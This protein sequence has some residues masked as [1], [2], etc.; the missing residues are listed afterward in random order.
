MIAMVVGIMAITMVVCLMLNSFFLKDLY[1]R[2]K[3]KALTGY[4]ESI[5]RYIENNDRDALGSEL[6]AMRYGDNISFYVYYTEQI[7]P[8]LAFRDDAGNYVSAA[9]KSEMEKRLKEI[10][11]DRSG[12]SPDAQVLESN[13]SFTIQQVSYSGAVSNSYMELYGLLR[14]NVYFLMR[15]PL[16]PVRE[17]ADAANRLLLITMVGTT[18]LGALLI[19]LSTQRVTG[20][21]LRLA[22]LSQHMAMLDFTSRYEGRQNNEISVLGSSMNRMSDKL[23]STIEELQQANDQL[24]K[25]IEEKI[26]IDEVRKEFLS[27]VSHELKTP[28]ALIQGYAE[29]LQDSVNDD[30]ESRNFY[31]EVIIDEA[32][33]MN[34][35]VKKLL[36]LNHLEFGQD[37]LSME[38]FCLSEMLD[39]VLSS[40]ELIA[41]G[42]GITVEKCYPP[43]CMAYADE[44]KIEE[45]CTNYIS[46]AFNHADGEKRI[47]V[48][49]DEEQERYRITVSNTG[50]RIPEDQLDKV[51]IKFYKVDKA[52]TREYGGSGIGLSIVKAVMDAHGE[53]YGVYNT[54]E[55][56][57]FWFC[58]RKAAYP[59]NS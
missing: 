8:Y 5:T 38:V 47:T 48:R 6:S 21:I 23:Q 57:A 27:N 44:F 11:F 20:P 4:Y 40:N 52:R 25:D 34:T 15:T 35:M 33:K 19:S 39:T 3:Q 32:A 50:N 9:E 59:E 41:Q 46:N 2:N 24:K 16:A 56:V 22:E 30:P 51:W 43:Q 28:I 26:Q 49:I 1:Y 17:S 55:G 7:L 45:V 42:K 31:C 10:F 18:L 53:P 54:A 12:Q 14:D 58:V 36:T 29:G 37:A 13:E